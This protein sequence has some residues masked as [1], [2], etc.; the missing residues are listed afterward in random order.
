MELVTVLPFNDQITGFKYNSEVNMNCVSCN[1]SLCHGVTVD[2]YTVHC[3]TDFKEWNCVKAVSP[4]CCC[5]LKN[6]KLITWGVFDK[7]G[8]KHCRHVI[9]RLHDDTHIPVCV[10]ETF[11]QACATAASHLKHR[12]SLNQAE[13]DA[14]LDPA[15]R[16]LS[17]FDDRKVNVEMNNI[18]HVAESAKPLLHGISG[19]DTRPAPRRGSNS[20]SRKP[21]YLTFVIGLFAI[22]AV[23]AWYYHREVIA[24][25]SS[26]DSSVL[27]EEPIVG[28]TYGGRVHFRLAKK[29]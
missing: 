10:Q 9:K 6:E 15:S 7:H 27:L 29:I 12:P 22:G 4:H 13:Q 20:N 25:D 18:D 24:I 23:F 16:P 14:L 1:I 11:A 26:F 17:G 3:G 19:Q 5:C 2:E 8:C 21:V 28:S